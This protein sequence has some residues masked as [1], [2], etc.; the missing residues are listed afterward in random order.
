M[1]ESVDPSNPTTVGV[2]RVESVA[3]P[4]AQRRGAASK[5]RQ[6]VY[7]VFGVIEALI[8][9]R[10]ALRL[11]GANPEAGFCVIRLRRHFAAPR[12]IHRAVRHAAAQRKRPRAAFHRGH[13][14]VRV[15]CLGA[16]EA[17]VA[18][19]GRDAQRRPYPFEQRRN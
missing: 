7:L 4:Y 12:A 1:A 8:A 16:C 15:G 3:D 14:R 11:L 9:I 18:G 10:F 2:E 5:V 6:G 13:P 19:Y 17:D